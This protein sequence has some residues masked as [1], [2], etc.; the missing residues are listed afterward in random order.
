[1][2]AD[3]SFVY[4]RLD[5]IAQVA[6][7]LALGRSVSEREGVEVPYLR[8]ANVQDGYI[9]TTEVKSVRV[10][11]GEIERYRVREGDLLLTEGGDLDKLGRG[12]VWDG[13][14]PLCLHQNHL[15]RVRSNRDLI[16]PEYLSLYVSSQWGKRYFLGVAKQTTNLAT[17]SS[18]QLKSMPILCPDLVVQRQ[19]LRVVDSVT[20]AEFAANA[21]IAK[22]RT[23]RAAAWDSFEL[24]QSVWPLRKLTDVGHLPSGQV[25]PTIAPYRDQQLLAPDHIEP[26]VGR[27]IG[28]VTAGE[29]GAISGKYVVGPG[30]VVMSKIRPA[31]RKVAVADFVGTCSADMYP[32]RAS[33]DI[34]SGYLG[35]A[36][37]GARF[38]RFAES[39]SGRTGIPKLNRDD[40]SGYSFHVPP[41]EVQQRIVGLIDDL[42]VK[43]SLE[44][45]R[46]DKITALKDA[47]VGD[48]LSGQGFPLLGAQP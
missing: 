27:I 17:I 3:D 37:L 45:A 36:L 7:G 30:D 47:L 8:V 46:R 1:M 12:A 4:R 40:L 43:E 5:S 28:R 20:E 38:S 24:G 16:L 10:L 44:A 31:L 9:D 26:G 25:D 33:S 2:S 32:L 41:V 42:A 35:A 18:S 39:V 34:L 48:L 11:P 23:L 6:G 13:H 22:L 15:F 21:A 14:I 19:M 29:Q